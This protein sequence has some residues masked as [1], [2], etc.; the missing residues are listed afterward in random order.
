LAEIYQQDTP[1]TAEQVETVLAVMQ[2]TQTEAYC[3]Q[4]L[5]EQCRLA[6]KA[7]KSVPHHTSPLSIRA[8]HDLE[9]MVRFIEEAAH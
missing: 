6:Y 8:H 7:L 1:V 5:A 4:F 3:H 9:I 2:R